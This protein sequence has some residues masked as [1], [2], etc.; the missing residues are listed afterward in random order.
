MPSTES[1]Q[2]EISSVAFL[3]VS[4]VPEAAIVVVVG[5]V[6]VDL[7][8]HGGP[9]AAS[10]EIE[11]AAVVWRATFRHEPGM[12][13]KRGPAARGLEREA[14]SRCDFMGASSVK[15][16][17]MAVRFFIYRGPAACPHREFPRECRAAKC[18]NSHLCAQEAEDTKSGSSPSSRLVQKQQAEVR[19]PKETNPPARV[20][21]DHLASSEVHLPENLQVG[22]K[23]PG[24][25]PLGVLR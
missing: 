9:G 11:A 19:C 8:A 5:V 6:P 1:S 13:V 3:V 25:C 4:A 2:A 23:Q 12:P 21:H 16:G 24:D 18:E 7:D 22:W 17:Y 10:P 15:A 20:L 14:G